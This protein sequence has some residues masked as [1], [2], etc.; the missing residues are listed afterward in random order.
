MTA[1]DSNTKL[2]L[3]SQSL[4]DASTSAH[5]QT[6]FGSAVPSVLQS[7]FGGSSLKFM[8]STS[9]YITS[10]NSSDFDFGTGDFTID[11]WVYEI[12]AALPLTS[13]AREKTAT[14]PPFIIN[15]NGSVWMSSNGAAWDIAVGRT[16]GAQVF[17]SWQHLEISRQGNTFRTFRNGVQQDTWTSTLGFPANS[18]PLAIGTC[19]NG[20]SYFNG[21]MDEIQIS[22]GIC[23]HTANFTPETAE[24]TTPAPIAPTGYGQVVC[25]VMASNQAYVDLVDTTGIPCDRYQIEF[26]HAVSDIEVPPTPSA[27]A[28]LTAYVS[29]D[30]CATHKTDAHYVSV[31]QSNFAGESNPIYNPQPLGFGV[32]QNLSM[33]FRLSVDSGDYVTH[34]ATG[35]AD[36]FNAGGNT[37][38]TSLSYKGAIGGTANTVRASGTWPTGAVGTPWLPSD[39]S[40]YFHWPIPVSYAG[41]YDGNVG[42]RPNAFRLKMNGGGNNSAIIKSGIFRLRR[43][44]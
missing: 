40:Q 29:Y 8:Q 7:K 41:H 10:S 15:Y 33:G 16:F 39:G 23:R 6:A 38:Y 17:N 9:D 3:H 30:L 12:S 19:Q 18:N 14:W 25:S 34:G 26:I 2:M 32:P 22:K 43:M 31:G 42:Q 44:S 28:V 24:Y 20:G 1:I 5:T 35:T 11:F 27:G 4:S 21:Y 36:I 13:I 37:I